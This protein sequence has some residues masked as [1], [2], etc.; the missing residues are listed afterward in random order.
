MRTITTKQEHAFRL[1]H[2]D[3]EGL[4]VKDAANYMG[5]SVRAIRNLLKS[6]E[7]VAPQ[8]FPIL[9]PRQQVILALYN[10]PMQ[11][12]IIAAGLRIS[13]CT[14]KREIAFLREH[15]FLQNTTPDQYR[16]RLDGDVKEKF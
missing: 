12:E 8:M 10:Q 3:F 5:T 7:E 16:E 14:L 6:V 2:H 11:H 1:C 9:T 4:S 13:R 15:N